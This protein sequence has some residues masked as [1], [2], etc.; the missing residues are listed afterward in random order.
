MLNHSGG[1]AFPAELLLWLSP[2]FPAGSF[3]Y[4]HGLENEVAE[5]RITDSTTLTEWLRATTAHGALRNDLILMSLACRAPD[6]NSLRRIAELAC[7]LQPSAERSQEALVQG[8]NFRMAYLA[9]WST[10]ANADTGFNA[11][12]DDVPVTHAVAIAIA[13]RDYRLPLPATL[14]AYGMS[15]H[16]N[17]ISAAI[18]L[19]VTGQFDGQRIL[20]ALLPDV[21]RVARL[22][23]N[24][25]EDDLGSATF[26]AD[27]ASMK[28]E[29][30][31]V[32]LF[33]S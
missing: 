6:G 4:S 29:T 3:A 21:R 9:A 28:H 20:A 23:E 10:D 30:Q 32:R 33:R 5:H 26:A 8:G 22:A 12:A 24:A 18:R 2:G 19:G 13:A 17:L 15:F 14:E 31:K 25:T 1:T 7:A 11:L 16:A 27:I